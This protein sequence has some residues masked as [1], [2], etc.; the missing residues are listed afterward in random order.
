[1]EGHKYL[2]NFKVLSTGN[3]C[4]KLLSPMLATLTT[5]ELVAKVS[6]VKLSSYYQN[7]FAIMQFLSTM[8]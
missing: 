3:G 7:H 8:Q 5:A 2:W 1:M 4:L 6:Y